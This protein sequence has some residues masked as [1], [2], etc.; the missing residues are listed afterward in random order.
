MAGGRQLSR[1]TVDPELNDAVALLIGDVQ[2]PAA[3]IDGEVAREVDIGGRV[4]DQ[5][6]LAARRIDPVAHNA[7]V[8]ATGGIEDLPEG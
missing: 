6:E 2:R 3:W 1:R 7:V 4:S 8:P 5:G